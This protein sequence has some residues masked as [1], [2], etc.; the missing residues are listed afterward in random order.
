MAIRQ[1]VRY[2]HPALGARCEPVTSFDA[3]LQRLADDLVDTMHATPGVG[4]T[5]A[6]I[7]VN[8]RLVV[9]ELEQQ[10]GPRVFVNPEILSASADQQTFDEGSVSMPGAIESVS[11]PAS[12]RVRYQGLDGAIHEEDMNGFLSTCMQHEIDQLDG[13]F[14]LQRL[15][16]LK[17]ERVTKKWEKSQRL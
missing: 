6:H 1:I 2:Q 8:K 15:S 12:I 10:F 13:I 17:R 3:D 11:R 7:G 4:I 14:W 5:A 16:R 9:I